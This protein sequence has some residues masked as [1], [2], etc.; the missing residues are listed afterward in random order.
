MSTVEAIWLAAC[1]IGCKSIPLALFICGI[2]DA[3][4]D[5]FELDVAVGAGYLLRD[6]EQVCERDTG[7]AGGALVEELIGR[8]RGL[9]DGVRVR[10]GVKGYDLARGDEVGGW[11]RYNWNDRFEP[12]MADGWRANDIY[13]VLLAV[14]HTG[15]RDSKEN[16]RRTVKELAS[17]ISALTL[18]KSW[19]RKEMAK[20]RKKEPKKSKTVASVG[21]RSRQCPELESL[22]DKWLPPESL[23]FNSGTCNVT[24]VAL[25]GFPG[26]GDNTEI[27]TLYLARR[28]AAN[29]VINNRKYKRPGNPKGYGIE[30]DLSDPQVL[31]NIDDEG[32]PPKPRFIH[33][34]FREF[35][36][37][38]D[39][40]QTCGSDEVATPIMILITGMD[41]KKA[42]RRT[43][44]LAF[45]IGCGFTGEY[46]PETATASE[47][48][49]HELVQ[50][51]EKIGSAQIG[52]TDLLSMQAV[53]KS[54]KETSSN[55]NAVELA[56]RCFGYRDSVDN[57]TVLA[58]K[59]AKVI[60]HLPGMFSYGQAKQLGELRPARTAKPTLP[61]PSMTPAQETKR[62]PGPLQSIEVDQA[63]VNDAVHFINEKANE[64]VYKAYE[65][66]GNYLLEKFFNN[67]IALASSKNPRKSASYSQLCKRED[68][69]IHPA[70]LGV[71]VRVAAQ[72]Q[73]FASKKLPSDKLSYTHKAE[74]VKL[75]DDQRK[76]DLVKECIKKSIASRQLAERVSEILKDTP[77]NELPALKLLE[78]KLS[79]PKRLFADTRITEMLFDDDRL[80]AEL[81]GLSPKK[82]MRLY[83]AVSGMLEES[84]EWVRRFELLQ[85]RLETKSQSRESEK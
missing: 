7:S 1:E 25:Q 47:E 81:E 19:K 73:F 40:M 8:L 12:S 4:A 35:L 10:E 72:E 59:L 31:Q 82:R 28:L 18:F 50:G 45:A 15:F 26:D 61:K 29:Y 39:G 71:M 30:A 36:S 65:E 83:E 68:L 42:D 85:S 2:D 54:V 3:K 74:L 9:R 23:V 5:E 11:L 77:R 14:R 38:S 49:L 70:R 64:H 55:V 48:F 44:G 80:R 32:T 79:D 34:T 52:G 84:R 33:K 78:N 41:D 53:L 69:A 60:A 16:L 13:S 62:N 6:K 66:I 57:I 46:Q 21:K 51:L 75:P 22:P 20:P 24:L 27:L 43:E 17:S 67:D 63:L 37:L 58:S 76:I 56:V